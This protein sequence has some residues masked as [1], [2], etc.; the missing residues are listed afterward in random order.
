M[1][2]NQQV[3]DYE[4]GWLAGI[5]EGEGYFGLRVERHTSQKSNIF[6]TDLKAIYIRAE[7]S[8]ANTDY[9]LIDKV[10]EIAKKLN[11]NMH[12]RN[13]K[14]Q[15]NR[16]DSQVIS[17]RSQRKIKDILTSTYPYLYGQKKNRA[18]CLINFVEL[19]MNQPAIDKHKDFQIMGFSGNG[20]MKPYTRK[21]IALFEQIQPMMRRGVNTSE[22]TKKMQN[23]ITE[24]IKGL[25]AYRELV[26]KHLGMSIETYFNTY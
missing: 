23:Q 18:N 13:Q 4:L 19:R 24:L 12:I 21:Q 8:V 5:I 22:T 26:E 3:K 17:T 1:I 2:D 16:K 15:G 9:S 7:W 11:C 20:S 6:S 10:N 25:M 14:G